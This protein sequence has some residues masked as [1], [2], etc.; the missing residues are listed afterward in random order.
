VDKFNPLEEA[1]YD[2]DEN[3]IK[4]SVAVATTKFTK[5]TLVNWCNKFG[6]GKKVGHRWYIHQEKLALLIKRGIPDRHK[7]FLSH[8]K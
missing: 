8:N 5:M 1:M 7:T 2:L 6:I 4:M 3:Y